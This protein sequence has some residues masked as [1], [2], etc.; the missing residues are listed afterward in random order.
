ML[1]MFLIEVVE[2]EAVREDSS[3][4]LAR[5]SLLMESKIQKRYW[6]PFDPVMDMKRC[7]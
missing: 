2:E 3:G 1:L 7:A 4:I 5:D 6:S